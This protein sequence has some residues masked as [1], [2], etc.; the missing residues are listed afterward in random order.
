M[1]RRGRL[2]PLRG[3]FGR[4]G[5]DRVGTFTPSA[6]LFGK[7]REHLL[8]LLVAAAGKIRDAQ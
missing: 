3:D 7:P 4:L 5:L 1:S 2:S 8:K 6:P